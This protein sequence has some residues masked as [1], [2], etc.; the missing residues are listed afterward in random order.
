ML[1]SADIGRRSRTQ[2]YATLDGLRGVAAALIAI[3]HAEPLFPGWAFPHSGLAVDMFFV[4]SGFVIANAYD[5]RL[6][7]G[8]TPSAFMRLRL[9]RLY[10]LYLVGLLLGLAAGVICWLTGSD[11]QLNGAVLAGPLVVGLLVLPTPLTWNDEI[12]P[13]NPPSWSLFFELLINLVYAFARDS[14]TTRR[15]III[16][17]VYGALLFGLTLQDVSLSGG[18]AWSSLTV[19]L[20]R[21]VFS[22]SMGLLLFRLRRRFDATSAPILVIAL[23]TATLVM[24]ECGK[25]FSLFAITIWLP[26]LVFTATAVEP[27]PGLRRACL[28]LGQISYPLY[29]LH[30][31]SAVIV[32]SALAHAGFGKPGAIAGLVFLGSM[33][34]VALMADRLQKHWINARFKDH[35]RQLP[36]YANQADGPALKIDAPART[37]APVA[38]SV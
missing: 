34:L 2:V 4:I 17:A 37:N 16:V 12:F 9:I 38:G 36:A 19:G 31:P 5:E 33:M 13:L 20:I 26:L 7:T 8:L 25:W 30:S 14:L 6:A 15:L 23:T 18:H 35:G 24:P 22:F 27:G 11:P 21:V 3:R 10:P 28:V 32:E 1:A 29:V